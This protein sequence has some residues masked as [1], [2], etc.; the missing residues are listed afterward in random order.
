MAKKI[1]I[2]FNSLIFCAIGTLVAMEKELNIYLKCL[3]T[4]N[5]KKTDIKKIIK[6]ENGHLELQHCNGT[7]HYSI[8]FFVQEKALILKSTTIDDITKLVKYEY[9]YPVLCRSQNGR[10]VALK[11]NDPSF[12][13][14]LDNKTKN[15]F[16]HILTNENNCYINNNG[17]HV[18]AI[19]N[20]LWIHTKQQDDQKATNT[21]KMYGSMEFHKRERECT[22]F[23]FGN[24]KPYWLYGNGDGVLEFDSDGKPE[25]ATT[26]SYPS[27]HKASIE[28]ITFDESDNHVLSYSNDCTLSIM[29]L[30]NKNTFKS[31]LAHKLTDVYWG[32]IKGFTDPVV[33][34][35]SQQ[36]HEHE[37]DTIDSMV[38]F[39]YFLT[40]ED[41]EQELMI[42]FQDQD[43]NLIYNN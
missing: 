1:R 15:D 36:K 19:D 32:T 8:N 7:T 14:I 22:A 13:Q 4:L 30:K 39:S 37:E 17:T 25:S 29:N 40:Q 12:I 28:K 26:I 24:R 6:D 38:K 18:I 9:E 3:Y 16:G 11:L 41:K 42:N 2:I 20:I 33:I 43:L 21:I 10:F 23:A 27:I 35:L 34:F 31:T 5:L